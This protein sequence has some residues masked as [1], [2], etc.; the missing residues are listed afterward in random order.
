MQM[1][2]T[3]QRAIVRQAH[4]EGVPVWAW[5]MAHPELGIGAP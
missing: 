5:M 1:C 2:K 3:T 4:R